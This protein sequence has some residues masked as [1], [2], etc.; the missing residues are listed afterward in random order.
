MRMIILNCTDAMLLRNIRVKGCN[1]SLIGVKGGVLVRLKA[2]L[3]F[4]HLSVYLFC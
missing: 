3:D 2:V 1:N 4:P